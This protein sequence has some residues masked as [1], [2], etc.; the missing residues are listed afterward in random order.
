MAYP[1]FAMDKTSFALC[2]IKITVAPCA[3]KHNINFF[4]IILEIF[5]II[6]HFRS[7]YKVFGHSSL[8]PCKYR[9]SPD[10]ECYNYMIKMKSPEPFILKRSRAHI[11]SF[12]C[13][14]QDVTHKAM[15]CYSWFLFSIIFLL[16]LQVKPCIQSRIYCRVTKF[17][18]NS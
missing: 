3:W 11:I 4:Q 13:K 16:H 15:A 7:N 6:P 14:S 1:L 12:Y 8:Y 9:V 2:S 10:N 18:L 17:L 5:F